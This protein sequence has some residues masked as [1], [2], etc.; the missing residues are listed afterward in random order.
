[1]HFVKPKSSK[2]SARIYI[3][4]SKERLYFHIHSIKHTYYEAFFFPRRIIFIIIHISSSSD[5]NKNNNKNNNNNDDD[6]NNNKSYQ[7]R[8]ISE[9]GNSVVY[10]DTERC[11]S[12]IIIVG[13]TGH[14]EW[15]A[16]GKYGNKIRS[17]KRDLWSWLFV[18]VR[19][20]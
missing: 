5:K 9:Y 12:E 2:P 20:L 7:W 8:D 1:M 16:V 10:M 3:V 6:G 17:S 11:S 4:Y 14:A 19:Y 13:S 15:W 18:G